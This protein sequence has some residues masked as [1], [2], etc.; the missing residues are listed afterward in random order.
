MRTPIWLLP[1]LAAL[2]LAPTG[3]NAHTDLLQWQ[4]L[5]RETGLSLPAYAYRGERWVAGTPGHRYALRLRNLSGERVLAVV[6]VDGVNVVTGA[7]A[8]TSQAGY[9]LAPYESADI[10]GWRKNLDEVAAFVFTAVPD[11]YA[12]RTGRPDNVG[13]LGVAVFAE[14][15]QRPLRLPEASPPESRD[16][17]DTKTAAA[18]SPAAERANEAARQ[19][20]GTGHGERESAPVSY[21]GFERASTKPAQLL[22][23][24]YDR[25]ERL[26]A[27]G[28]IA[29]PSAPQPFP[30]GF[31][32]DPPG[33]P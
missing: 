5:D 21:T 33:S 3:A 32:P 31:V 11:S 4:V 30:L 8:T 26:L 15:R 16:R 29:S 23:L 25:R 7:S 18:P 13:V 1:L 10:A 20:L 17:H 19:Q 2:A 22:T 6:S 28:V 24:R 27:M 14:R 9:V 12:A